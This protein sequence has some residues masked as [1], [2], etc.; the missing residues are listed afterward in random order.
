M[1]RGSTHRR[2]GPGQV[3]TLHRFLAPLPPCIPS[4]PCLSFSVLFSTIS[5][6]LSFS[7]CIS[8]FL[9]ALPLQNTAACEVQSFV[10][11]RGISLLYYHSTTFQGTNKSIVLTL[12]TYESIVVPN[13][14]LKLST[15]A[16]ECSYYMAAPST[17]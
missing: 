4:F 16:G 2:G 17:A 3:P 15:G 14:L 9:Q 8:E 1:G 11:N 7:H 10:G 5:L 12:M 6:F 13:G